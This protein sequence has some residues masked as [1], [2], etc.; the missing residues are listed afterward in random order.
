VLVQELT[1]GEY[2]V[3]SVFVELGKRVSPFG[4]MRDAPS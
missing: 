3:Y 4:K 1:C 2:S